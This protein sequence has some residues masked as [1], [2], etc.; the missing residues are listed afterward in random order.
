MISIMDQTGQCH[1]YDSKEEAVLDFDF[2]KL[3]EYPWSKEVL[4]REDFYFPD[5]IQKGGY[6]YQGI[7]SRGAIVYL[8]ECQG[9]KNPPRE[10]TYLIQREAGER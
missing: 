3:H 1:N 2:K 10:I 5:K 9:N 6:V 8:P 4:G 7:A